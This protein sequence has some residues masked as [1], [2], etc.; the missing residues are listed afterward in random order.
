MFP[1]LARPC[2][3]AARAPALHEKRRP[4]LYSGK[5]DWIEVKWPGPS[6][7][8]ERLTNLPINRYITIV[9]GLDKWQ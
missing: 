3:S 1:T 2:S 6:N 9:E 4:N 8:T 7:V 5:I